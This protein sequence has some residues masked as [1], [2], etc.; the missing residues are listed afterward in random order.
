[1][2]WSFV[3]DLEQI[4]LICFGRICFLCPFC[5]CIFSNIFIRNIIKQIQIITSIDDNSSCDN[6]RCVCAKTPR[7]RLLGHFHFCCSMYTQILICFRLYYMCIATV[8]RLLCI[9]NEKKNIMKISKKQNFADFISF[10][11]RQVFFSQKI[12][13]AYFD[14]K[15]HQKWLSFKYGLAEQWRIW[16]IREMTHISKAAIAIASS[17]VNNIA[18]HQPNTG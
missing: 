4:Y 5:T 8:H 10:I 17:F 12:W 13:I 16:W 14:V 11:Y 6:N 9:R 1:M 18:T 3:I 2:R 15:M 7:S